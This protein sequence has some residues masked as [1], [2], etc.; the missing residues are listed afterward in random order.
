MGTVSR[1]RLRDVVHTATEY[2]RQRGF[3]SYDLFDAL[4]SP[5]IDLATRPWPLARRL[6]IQLL[7]RS[8]FN[9]RP[10]LGI[11][12]MVHTKTVS[13]MLSIY[14][15]DYLWNGNQGT[16]EM[17]SGTLQRLLGQALHTDGAGAI[18]WGLNVPYTTR[19]VNA[20]PH[21]PNLFNTVNAALLKPLPGH[22]PPPLGGESP[23]APGTQ[24]VTGSPPAAAETPPSLE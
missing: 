24:V 2:V 18:A 9:V 20:G 6:A 15:L 21:T 19:F 17:A 11:R 1:E 12:P 23:Y 10:L 16:R 22:L 7:R 13:D 8:P 3:E 14:S 4:R 5:A